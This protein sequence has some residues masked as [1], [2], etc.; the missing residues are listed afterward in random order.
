M[1]LGKADDESPPATV[2]MMRIDPYSKSPP[3]LQRQYVRGTS[4]LCDGMKEFLSNTVMRSSVIT[5]H[6][7][8]SKAVKYYT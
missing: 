7:I 2:H 1:G 6:Q 3:Y 4:V 5:A 8:S